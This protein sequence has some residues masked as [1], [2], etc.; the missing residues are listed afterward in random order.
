MEHIVTPS[1]VPDENFN[2]W[3]LP[4]KMGLLIALIKIIF[5]TV[6]YQFFLE[7]WG[8]TMLFTFLSFTLGAVLLGVTG[9]QQRKA[10]G[11]YMDI[12]QA[13]QAIFIAALIV[14]V[15]NFTY[16]FIYMRFIDASMVDKIRESSISAAENWGA[17]QEK[18]DEMAEEFDKQNEDKLN[19][20]KQLLSIATQIVWYG[21]VSFIC[22]AIVKKNKPVYMD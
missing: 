15:L 12:K 7:S 14:V 9:V 18:L 8:M 13:F 2:K 11:G 6:A 22:A 4:V 1:T 20:G 16:D 19:F 17:P 5:S 10:L 21:I 3:S